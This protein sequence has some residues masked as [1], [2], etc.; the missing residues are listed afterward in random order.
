MAYFTRPE[1]VLVDL[2]DKIRANA[3]LLGL[4]E[5]L[6]GEE[7]VQF[8]YPL[9]QIVGLP[10]E[11]DIEG[12]S[13]FKVIFHAEIWI[14]HADLSVGHE[15]R[16]IDEMKLATEVVRFLHRDNMRHLRADDNSDRL[17]FAYVNSELP[18]RIRRPGSPSIITT[19]L[20]WQGESR[21]LFSQES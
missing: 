2:R 18:G 11:R 15:Q 21:V 7:E 12:M 4:K 17:I 5:V 16:T 13:Y 20:G 8:N 1:E 10:I 3:S 19:R 9:C 14:Y 6:L